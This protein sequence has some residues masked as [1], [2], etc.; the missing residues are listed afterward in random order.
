MALANGRYQFIAME[1]A[2]LKVVD[3]DQEDEEPRLCSK[4][5]NIKLDTRW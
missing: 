2:Q 5:V 4:Q 3:D 1:Q